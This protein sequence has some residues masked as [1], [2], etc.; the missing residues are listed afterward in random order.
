VTE[1]ILEGVNKFGKQI[2]NAISTLRIFF[3]TK[4]YEYTK[5]VTETF[6]K[7]I[8]EGDTV[9]TKSNIEKTLLAI[10]YK[11]TD[12]KKKIYTQ[13]FSAS[14]SSI[15]VDCKNEKIIYP[16]A[17]KSKNIKGIVINNEIICN[18]ERKENFVV[19][20]C[21]TR[22]LKKGYKPEDLETEKPWQLGHNR[23]SG[24][25]DIVIYDANTDGEDNQDHND[26]VLAIIECK[27]FGKEYDKAKKDTLTDGGQLFS[28]WQQD[29]SAKWLILYASELTENEIVEYITESINGTDDKNMLE[30]AKKDSSILL[31]ANASKCEELY[32]VW[33]ETY[34]KRLCGDV[35]F[36]DDTVAYKIGLKPLRKKDLKDFGAN[37]GIV[38]KFEEILRHNNVSDKENAFNRLV[39]LFICKL[40]DELQ[41][42]DN[43][44]VEFQYKVGIDTYETLQDR[45]QRLHKDGMKDFMKEDIFYVSEKYAEDIV[46]KYTGQNR[47]KLVE[48]LQKTIRILKFFTNNDFAFKDVHNEEL[49]YQNGKVLVEVVQLFQNFRITE[50]KDIQMIGD[51]FEQLLNKGFKQNEGQFFTPTPITRFMWESLPLEKIMKT[52]RGVKYPKIID[53]ACGAGHFLTE[54]VEVINDF[55][56]DSNSAW[57]RDNIYGIEKDYRLARVSKI[58]LFMHGA[59][60]G[61]IIFGDG[62]ENYKEKGIVPETFDILIANP[63]YSVKAFK[64]H[65][66][67]KEN[68]LSTLDKISNE[69]SEIETLFVERI[70]Q[71]LKP[72]G[73][74]AVILPSS[75][76]N[77]EQES[78]VAARE[79][80]LK[81]FKVHAIAQMGSKTFGATGTNTVI[82]FLEKYNEPPKRIDMVDDSVQAILEGKKLKDWEDENIFAHYLEKIAVEEAAYKDFI[83]REKDYTEWADNEYFNRYL[84]AFLDSTEYKTQQSKKIFKQASDEE[85]TKWCNARFYNF[86]LAAESE[87]LTYFA[88]SYSQT[89]LIVSAPTDNAEQEKFL[90][91][92]WSNR[93]G[94]EGIQLLSQGGMLSGVAKVIN[95]S[96]KDS[97]IILPE[98][99][100]YCYT[101]KLDDM[102]N[103]DASTFS[104]AI[105]TVKKRETKTKA[106]YKNERL[107]SSKFSISIGNRVL[108]TELVQDGKYP[109]Y[110]ANVFEPF[111]RIDKLNLQD[112]SKPSVIWGIDGDWMVNCISANQPFYPTDHCGVLRVNSDDIL[113]EYLAVALDIE[114]QYEKF[115]RSNRAS[116][117][118][119][120]NLTIPIPPLK[121]QKEIVAEYNKINSEIN[122]ENTLISKL[123]KN[124]ENKFVEM[125][126]SS[127]KKNSLKDAC[128]LIRGV[129]YPKDKVVLSPTKNAIL[130]AD[131]ITSSN[132]FNL[133]KIIYIDEHVALENERK[134]RKNDIFICLSSGST[135]HVGK[136]AL[137][138]DDV[139]YY[140]GGFMGMLRA[141]STCS[142]RY[143]FYAL[144]SSE[145]KQ[146]FE[147]NATGTNIKNLSSSI[148]ELPIFI[149]TAREQTKFEHFAHNI[150][151][152]QTDAKAKI[153]QLELKKQ[154]LIDKYFM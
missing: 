40:V 105:K 59:G 142:S 123:D 57:V 134:L 114:G 51:M 108:A 55:A 10:G 140:A 6:Y 79:A 91:Y 78:F 81:N 87:K 46:Y 154:K 121:L 41:K 28:Y 32:R 14:K 1:V 124:I 102:L 62:L 52:K 109:V 60:D 85:K 69:G 137:I 126:G 131:N 71:L 7:C 4:L 25:A 34:D 30:A 13:K 128:V 148:M 65:L 11:C 153:Q 88:L 86:A 66:K 111:G 58:A 31:Y 83:S 37:D 16:K 93:K 125:F 130:T 5:I 82:L 144:T 95:G 23:K 12:S 143:L 99:E 110:S 73:I 18:F 42:K 133:S 61:N 72:Q 152:Q 38:N 3:D 21:I 17:D 127:D 107:N 98:L 139:D 118:R 84:T 45:L 136:V 26:K 106:G 67:L 120:A 147:A 129:T 96:F 100:K 112:F 9:I 53:Y 54:G 64:P 19:L 90:G 77:K 15:T 2:M 92:N 97:A 75:I 104:N 22:L 76:L 89:V 132:Q 35:L 47:K 149:P 48:D 135:K 49:F 103:F 150:E 70:A 20:E 29:K 44:E 94:Q 39:A 80:I 63:P 141:N 36:N 138:K 101:L 24:D 116:T 8:S 50:S 113:P 115:S 33:D 117:E 27:T 74:A 145:A 56:N 122:S 68:R 151:Q 119:I 146:Y 43:D